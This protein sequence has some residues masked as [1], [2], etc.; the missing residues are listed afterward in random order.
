MSDEISTAAELDAL[1]VRTLAENAHTLIRKA[2]DGSWQTL[3]AGGSF[4]WD[5]E[6]VAAQGPWTVLYRPD[7]PERTEPTED[8]VLTILRTHGIE[9]TG[10]GEVTCFGCRSAGWMTW[11]EYRLHL[12]RAVIALLP[13]RVAPSE[14]TVAEVR[15]QALRDAAHDISLWN[16][17]YVP[18]NIQNVVDRLRAL[19]ERGEA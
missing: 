9:C 8:Q 14:E 2:P 10:L 15:A 5:S 17:I 3:G 4:W 16:T 12:A 19:A 18:F 13:Q 7:A 11:S 6:H 1:P